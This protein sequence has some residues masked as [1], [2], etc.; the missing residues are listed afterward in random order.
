MHLTG[1]SLLIC[2][3]HWR[4]LENLRSRGPSGQA[5]PSSEIWGPPCNAVGSEPFGVEALLAQMLQEAAGASAPGL[6]SL[7]HQQG[8]ALCGCP[9]HAR[10]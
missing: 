9:S 7:S 3:Q 6:G 2:A 8:F 10:L 4:R 1:L 5:W